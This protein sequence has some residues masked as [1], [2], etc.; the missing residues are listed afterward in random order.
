MSERRED[1]WDRLAA[2]LAAAGVPARVDRLPYSE[3]YRGRPRSGVSSSITI[4]VRGWGTVDVRDKWWNKNPDKWVGWEV[5]A[6]DT[7]GIDRGRAARWTKK[8]SE[9]VTAVLARMPAGSVT[10]AAGST[11]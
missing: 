7:E 4:L 1:R 2:D 6:A 5:S 9:V 10:P 3:I 8:R 11:R